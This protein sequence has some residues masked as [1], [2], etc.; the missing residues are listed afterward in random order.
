MSRSVT[1]SSA[2]ARG[3]FRVASL[4]GVML[5]TRRGVAQQAE[6]LELD[7]DAPIGCPS[8]R[9]V[10]Q[11]VRKLLGATKPASSG[12]RAEGTISRGTGSE[13]HLKLVIH[14]D[15]LVGERHIDGKSCDDLAGAAAVALALLMSSEQPLTE[16]DWEAGGET[17]KPESSTPPAA[18]EPAA[19]APPKP[20]AKP[21]PRRLHALIDFP[22]ASVGFGPLERPSLG[23]AFAGGLSF[24]DWRWYLQERAWLKQPFATDQADAG[25]SITRFDATLWT[26]RALVIGNFEAAP[27][28]TLGV[29]H[30]A[31]RGT[32]TYVTPRTATATWF[33]AGVG[34]QARY[35]L[36]SWFSFGAGVDAQ[37]EV[38]RPQIT[39]DDVGRLGRFSP[40]AVTITVGPEWIL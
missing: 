19:P 25:A 20:A 13:W 5:A 3:F 36:A 22:I 1:P 40:A 23:A 9:D 16:R 12:L 18:P 14:A 4:V 38:S 17:T 26:C 39:V 30:V 24:A 15:K 37:Y 8:E 35:V 29:Q 27:C 6:P 32:G 28:L 34:L 33:A 21:R 11:R 2:I 10:A 31:A 7:W